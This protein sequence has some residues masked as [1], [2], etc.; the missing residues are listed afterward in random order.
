MWWSWSW[1]GMSFLWWIFWVLLIIGFFA[2]LT[3]V[4]RSQV[5]RARLTP[6]E[7]LQRR[8][9]SGELTTAEYEER[10]QRLLQDRELSERRAPQGPAAPQPQ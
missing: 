9:A 2:F 8:Y 5:P 1:F 4:P 7:I 3:P 10:K 6:L